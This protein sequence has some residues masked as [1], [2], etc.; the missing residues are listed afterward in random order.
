LVLG[1]AAVDRPFF[2][3]GKVGAEPRGGL[4]SSLFLVLGGAVVYQPFFVEG[5]VGTKPWGDLAFFSFLL[6]WVLGFSL[7]S[8][9]ETLDIFWTKEIGIEN[10]RNKHLTTINSN[11]NLM[12]NKTDIGREDQKT[13]GF[14]GGEFLKQRNKHLTTINSNENLMKKQ[15]RYWERRSEDWGFCW[16]GIFKATEQAPHHNKFQWKFDE[17]TKQ[18]LGEKIRRLGVLLEGN[19]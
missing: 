18:I 4:A 10:Q 15:N 17:K 5:K 14:V 13:G 19:F 2:V 7:S 1:G 8:I 3:V 9:T 12:K 16:R 11:E 6:F